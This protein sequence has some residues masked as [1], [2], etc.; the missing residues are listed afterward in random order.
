LK[1]L[2]KLKEWLTV[3]DAA[4][5]LSILFGEDLSEADV[6]RLGL[7]GHLTLSVDFVNH[8]QA[9]CGKIIPVADAKRNVIRIDENKFI[10]IIEGIHLG[11]GRV[12]AHGEGVISIY[13]VWDLS[14]IGSERLDIEH[15]YQRLTGG[16][17]VNLSNLEGPLVSHPDGTWARIV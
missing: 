13:G 8:A 6:L 7:D 5:H 2:L 11:D 12:I 17:S 10:H 4:R 15:K 1:K 9:Q 14:M 16:P 3:P